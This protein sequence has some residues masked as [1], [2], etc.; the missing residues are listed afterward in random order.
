MN[1]D[2]LPNT[3]YHYC[4]TEAFLS[5]IQKKEIWL[6]HLILSNDSMEGKMAR[7]AIEH[8]AKG[9]NLD[10]K[11]KNQLI[12]C[13]D[14]LQDI[15]SGFGFCLSAEGDL[16]SQ[17]R[18]YAANGTGISIGFSRKF[19]TN[20][21]SESKFF[22]F[23]QVKYKDHEHNEI[24]RNT[25]NEIKKH[26][27]CGAF[28][29]FPQKN[30]LSS[31]TENDISKE[32]SNIINENESVIT[33]LQKLFPMLYFL[34]S[35]SFQEEKEWRLVSSFPIAELYTDIQYRHN[36]NIILPYQ[37]IKID[38]PGESIDEIILGPK[39]ETPHKVIKNFLQNHGFKDTPI[40][41]SK[42]SYR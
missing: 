20:I 42:L 40:K 15:Y 33:K 23:E 19:F 1:K 35:E 24:V 7:K 10:E 16:L 2:S 12:L 39:H 17:W 28:K 25:Y 4:S 34:K 6:S 22:G 29:L 37:V 26:I 18:A 32:K 31:Q 36:N 8:L 14:V 11:I 27:K 3:F 21:E 9:D 38:K 30:Y 5:I 13:I 41:P